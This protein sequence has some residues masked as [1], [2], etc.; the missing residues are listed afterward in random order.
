M[1][2]IVAALLTLALVVLGKETGREWGIEKVEREN[3]WEAEK[4]ERQNKREDEKQERQNQREDEKQER[5][6]KRAHEELMTTK[7]W[8][9]DL[10]VM[11]KKAGKAKEIHDYKLDRKRL[12]IRELELQIQLGELNK[13][14]KNQSLYVILGWAKLPL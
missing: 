4:Q 7:K 5:K 6:E 11:D 12:K 3:K 10:A 1:W 13:G 14:T 9:H 2:F 8:E